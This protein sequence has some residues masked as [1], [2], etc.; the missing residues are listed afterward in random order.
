MSELWVPFHVALSM[1]TESIGS[2]VLAWDELP[3]LLQD[4]HVR[5]IAECTDIH[6]VTGERM[7]TYDVPLPKE[8]WSQQ[9]RFHRSAF[10]SRLYLMVEREERYQDKGIWFYKA[11]VYDT[12]RL[13]VPDLERHA[14]AR[15]ASK[16]STVE[17]FVRPEPLGLPAETRKRG[18]KPSKTLAVIEA[19]KSFPRA[20]LAEMSEKNMAHVFKASRDTCRRAREQ[21]LSEFLN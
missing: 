8:W 7:R 17:P 3:R 10:D 14:P 21:V 11:Q 5:A 18:P 13:F 4:G 9:K 15:Q 1:V 20:E 2:Q 12:V 19:M 16:L 6:E